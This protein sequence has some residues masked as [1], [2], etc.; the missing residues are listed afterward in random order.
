M[1]KL[2]LKLRIAITIVLVGIAVFL[3]YPP[4]DTKD[5]EGKL[6]LGLDLRWYPHGHGCED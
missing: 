4:L 3:I 1:S 5:R 6:N 2:D